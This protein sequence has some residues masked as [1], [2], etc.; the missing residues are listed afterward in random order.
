VPTQGQRYLNPA[1]GQ[2]LIRLST[3]EDAGRQRDL[4]AIKLPLFGY[5]NKT[6]DK[7]DVLVEVFRGECEY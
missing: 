1:Q 3:L 7:S 5:L 2:E 4:G 6:L